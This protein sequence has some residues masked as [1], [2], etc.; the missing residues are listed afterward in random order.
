ML[1][2]PNKQPSHNSTISTSASWFRCPKNTTSKSSL[3]PGTQ[4]TSGT[5][6][7]LTL[8]WT[9]FSLTWATIQDSRLWHMTAIWWLKKK[10]K[11]LFWHVY[12]KFHLCHYRVLGL[13]LANNTAT[14]QVSL[15][16]S[17]A[18]TK[19]NSTPPLDLAVEFILGSEEFCKQIFDPN[20]R[21]YINMLTTRSILGLSPKQDYVIF[22]NQWNRAAFH[23]GLKNTDLL[24]CIDEEYR[25]NN[26]YLPNWWVNWAQD[27]WVI[28]RDWNRWLG[29][30]IWSSRWL[31][32]SLQLSIWFLTPHSGE[33]IKFSLRPLRWLIQNAWLRLSTFS[34]QWW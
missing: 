10:D 22:N 25:K 8:S 26:S 23:E 17:E 27:V 1:H 15:K 13:S 34:R 20:S 18:K 29:R 11:P 2:P 16:L 9:V 14:H 33:L 21:P 7:S 32:E 5:N 24:H 12:S 4:A 6:W 3:Q 28:I 19:T 31:R 30:E